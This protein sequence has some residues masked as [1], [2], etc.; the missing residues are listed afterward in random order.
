MVCHFKSRCQ[1]EL[2]DGIIS[3]PFI[4]D[5]PARVSFTKADTIGS[6]E[7]PFLNI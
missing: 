7:A 5:G 1:E 3:Y 6:T 2:W 4:K